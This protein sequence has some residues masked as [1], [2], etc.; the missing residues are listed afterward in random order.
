MNIQATSTVL[1]YPRIG[2]NRELK[3]ALEGY[4]GG[5]LTADELDATAAAIRG[6]TW[7]TLRSAGID[8]IP[9]NTFSYYDQVL[10]TTVA[11]GAIPGRFRALD[12]S[13]LD[14]Y[15]AAARGTAQLPPLELTKWF[16]TNY[17]YLVPE[18]S[19]DT[20]FTANPA[21]ALAELDEARELGI[22]TRPVLVGPLT[23]LLSAK[24]ASEAP[25]NF[26]PLDLLPAL[27]E[28]YA[29]LLRA[30]AEAGADW[31]QL[32]EPALTADR[33]DAELASAERAY[34]RLG[35]LTERPRLLVAGYFG[36]FAAALP[37]LLRTPIDGIAVDLVSADGDLASLIEGG[38]LRG[39]RVVAGV[40]DGRNIWRADLGRALDTV[41]SL[42]EVTGDL[43]VGTSCSL[44]HV[45]LDLA[46]EPELDD[47]LRS[48]V[49]FARQKL[50]EVVAVA[51][52]GRG[53]A[54]AIA[55]VEA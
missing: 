51:R 27:V 16:D 41:R 29:D 15:F 23:F 49:A 8:E 19:P 40:V 42:S 34:A 2:G 10:D 11:V 46:A 33:S 52:A 24:A 6:E 17:H 18:L 26:R 47:R 5:R 39:R 44:L 37:A 54:L 38:Q 20:T 48:H 3:R 50:D 1:G 32:D 43:V 21:K 45:P 55:S 9:S 22:A 35:E 31:V 36:E 4:W 30:L 12:L 7:S 53:D 13:P 25:A 28:C 14:T